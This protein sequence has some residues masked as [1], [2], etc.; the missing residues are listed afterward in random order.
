MLSCAVVF[1]T[2]SLP[3]SAF[4]QS[5]SGDVYATGSNLLRYGTG[6]TELAPGLATDKQY[7]EEIADARVFFENFQLGL[8][9]E[10]DDP[11]E[12][13]RSYPA[14]LGFG[15]GPEF[16]RRWLAYRKDDVNIQA[17]DVN[18]LYGRGLAVNLFESRP[19]NYDSWLEGV[20]GR[21]EYRIPKDIL[22]LG[23]SIKVQGIGGEETY[24][25]IDTTQLP[26]RISA[27]AV[28]AEFGFFKKKLV[29]G[30]SFVQ[31]FTSQSQSGTFGSTITT[32][33]QVNEPEFYVDGNSGA[34]EGFLEWT[35]DRTQASQVSDV[36][37]NVFG[38]HHFGHAWY[39]SLSYASEDFGLTFEYKNYAY[40]IHNPSQLDTFAKLPIT[41]P[42]EVYK[43]FTFTEIT[44]TTHAV[45]FDDE[46]GYQLEAN[47]TAVPHWVIDLDGA[48]SS[49]HNRYGPGG[50]I[51]DST[52]FLPKLSDQ[53]FYPFWEYYAEAEWDFDPANTLNF[54][55]F[56]IHHRN[57][58]IA[59]NPT[60]PGQTDYRWS[61]TIAAKFQYETTPSESILAIWEHQW[62]FDPSTYSGTDNRRINELITLEYSF[63]PTINF[64][65]I[66]DYAFFY[67]SSFRVDPN[68]F[69][70]WQLGGITHMPEVFVGLRL[71]QSHSMLLQ[72]G[73]ERGGLNCAGGIC[74]VVPPFKGL[75][76]TLTSQI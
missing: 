7:F 6:S 25:P 15:Q 16:R 45:N 34:F 67:T 14:T 75:R 53:G 76:L 12:V 52:S 24:F 49:E 63:N 9:Y 55:K 5:T 20:S 51:A 44:R 22:D 62:A 61:T 72:Y 3:R 41:S 32:R 18:A 50:I 19:L 70:G 28:N 27:R 31:A 40:N 42:P 54:V 65:A 35:E 30:T 64:G 38:T 11:S 37:G 66:F 10:L 73:A 60:N 13:G 2:V 33:Q 68:A 36:L 26:M 23:A 43:D 58:V 69:D 17:G 56:A 8:R 4:S 46:L 57:D 59:Y 47:I 39:S 74:R 21:G 71:G 48:A 29:L 1:A